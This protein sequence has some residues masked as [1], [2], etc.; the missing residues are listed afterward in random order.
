MAITRTPA[1]PIAPAGV[2]TFV[3]ET[4]ALTGRR[5]KHVRR[6]PGRLVGIVMNPLVMMLAVGYLFKK[7]IVVPGGGNYAEYLMAGVALQVGLASLGPT[8]ISVNLDLRGGLMERYRSLPISRASVLVAHSLCDLLIGTVALAVVS[9]VGLLIG[10]RPHTDLWRVAAGF[11]LLV[12]FIYVMVWIGI[13]LGMVVG[14]PESIDSLGALVLVLF[15]FLSS[16]ILSTR[17]LPSWIRPVADWN[18]V[19]AVAGSCR[20]LWGNPVASSPGFA[21]ERPAVV[22]VLS[23]LVLTAGSVWLS[24]RRYRRPSA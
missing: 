21:S 9:L 15:S 14:Q 18:P 11:L 12:A 1:R 10:W 5:L 17:A 2:G 23:F 24:L 13:A 6:A 4:M 8:A 3:A 20:R 16:A 22:I 19:S 7:S